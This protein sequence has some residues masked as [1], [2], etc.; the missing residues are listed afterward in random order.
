LG[1][2]QA[3]PFGLQVNIN[4]PWLN[5]STGKRTFSKPYIAIGLTSRYR[6]FDNGYY[7]QLFREIPPE[8]LVF[9]GTPFDQMERCSIQ[10]QHFQ[11]NHFSEITEVISNCE[12]FIGNPSFLYALA[13]AMKAPRFVEVPENNNV[14]PIGLGGHLLHQYR[15]ESLRRQLIELLKIPTP[16]SIEIDLMALYDEVDFLKKNAEV[17]KNPVEPKAGL[18]KKIRRLLK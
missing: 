11:S 6:R 5:K 9:I 14:Y 8:N 2:Q 15:R 12:A 10:G 17:L 4:D 18:A 13:E 7:E 1:F 3:L 16:R